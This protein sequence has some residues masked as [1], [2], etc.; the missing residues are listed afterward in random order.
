M[1]SSTARKRRLSWK[2]ILEQSDGEE[3]STQWVSCLHP[4]GSRA[5]M[6][7]AAQW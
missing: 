2:E 4:D 5:I 7:L 6:K 1:K 3:E